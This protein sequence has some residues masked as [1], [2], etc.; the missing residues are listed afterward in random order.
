MED[1]RM[2]KQRPDERERQVQAAREPE[3]DQQQREGKRKPTQIER[4]EWRGS[5]VCGDT[6]T[7]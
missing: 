5:G 2:A 4:R 1:D 6:H 3:H 7:D